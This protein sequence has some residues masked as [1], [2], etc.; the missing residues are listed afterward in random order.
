MSNQIHVGHDNAVLEPI[1][2]TVQAASLCRLYRR[3]GMRRLCF[4]DRLLL[5]GRVEYPL[6][7]ILRKGQVH[8]SATD[9]LRIPEF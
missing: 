4:S 8:N 2:K 1:R 7:L 3:M 6:R 9:L 5:P